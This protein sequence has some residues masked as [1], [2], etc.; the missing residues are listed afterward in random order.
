MDCI[1]GLPCLPLLI[2]FGQWRIL[3]ELGGRKKNEVRLFVPWL[4]PGQ[5]NSG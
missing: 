2:G 3:A 5:V 4:L 1:N